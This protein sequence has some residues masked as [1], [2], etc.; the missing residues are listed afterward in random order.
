MLA[1]LARFSYQ[2]RK[3][4]VLAWILFLVVA[5]FAGGALKGEWETSGGGLPGTDSQAGLRPPE[6][7]VPGP[8]R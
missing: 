1:R 5:M 4:V 8:V 6:V 2:R 7:G 3:F